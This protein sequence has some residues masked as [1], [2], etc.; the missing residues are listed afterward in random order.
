VAVGCISDGNNRRPPITCCCGRWL[1]TTD[2]VNRDHSDGTEMERWR[3]GNVTHSVNRPIIRTPRRSDESLNRCTVW[4]Y[5]SVQTAVHI[6]HWMQYCHNSKI[7]HLQLILRLSSKTW[8]LYPTSTTELDQAALL[9]ERVCGA[10]KSGASAMLS[11]EPLL[12][13]ADSVL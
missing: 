3:N 12:H 10:T 4:V 5:L 13:G 1:N 2:S 7:V 8:Q 9:D 11:G 6:A